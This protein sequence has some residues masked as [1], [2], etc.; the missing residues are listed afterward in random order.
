MTSTAVRPGGPVLVTGATGF[1][2]ACLV[3][4]LVQDAIP[5]RI[6]ARSAKR[7]GAM[8][9]HG[10]DIV[11]GDITDRTLVDE[12]T[13]GCNTVFHLAAAFREAGLKDERY[14]Q[15]HVEGT[16]HVLD[17]ARKHGIGRVVHCST[18]GVLS[19]I[20]HPPADETL[21]YAP[22]DIYQSTK[23][24][25]EQLALSYFRDFGIPVTVARPTSIYGPGDMRLLKLFRMVAKERFIMI[26]RGEVFLHLVHVEDLVR[27]LR[28]LA[29]HP[30]ALGEI[31]TIG[32][33]EYRT[34]NDI[35]SVIAQET[36]VD[37]PRWRVPA[38]PIQLLGS[39]C[40]RICIPLGITPPIY[41]RRVDFFTKS[42]AFNIDK[43]KTRLGYQ[44][45]IDLRSGIRETIEWY[46][47]NGLLP[48][49]AGPTMATSMS[50]ASPS[51]SQN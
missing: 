39:L 32:G 5:V 2:G 16:R 20:E 49:T 26:G 36:G 24:E 42:R 25:G 40:E 19:H 47:K 23:A 1:T 38:R 22:G 35:V 11:E 15:V 28:I 6:L 29:A 13:Y 46:R 21:P 51:S 31:F 41:R 27:G 8:F 9:P 4:S 18:I 37:R 43:A 17:A 33:E 50:G 14:H 12:C 48:E 3:R 7:A 30:A 44:P 45:L 10:V 34:L